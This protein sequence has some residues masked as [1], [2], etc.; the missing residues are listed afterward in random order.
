MLLLLHGLLHGM[1]G[2]L[3]YL[4]PPTF[5]RAFAFTFALAV[6]ARPFFPNFALLFNNAV[7]VILDQGNGFLL[8]QVV[9]GAVEQMVAKFVDGI[10]MGWH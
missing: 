3:S 10:F 7:P 6:W 5:A 2:D 4:S 9:L 1:L 8:W